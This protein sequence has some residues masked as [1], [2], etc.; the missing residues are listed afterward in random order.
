MSSRSLRFPAYDVMLATVLLVGLAVA[1]V[2]YT[3]HSG[4]VWE[5]DLVTAR[6]RVSEDGYFK[7]KTRSIRETAFSTLASESKL[8]DCA[9]S[10]IWRHV[11]MDPTWRNGRRNFGMSGA[12]SALENIATLLYSESTDSTEVRDVVQSALSLLLVEDVTGI[13]GVYFDLIDE[14]EESH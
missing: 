13:E 12:V 10:P 14:D 6:L 3:S 4:E 9:K 5:I 2:V 11:Y 8:I 1:A 7:A